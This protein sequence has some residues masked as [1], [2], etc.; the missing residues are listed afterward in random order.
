VTIAQVEDPLDDLASIDGPREGQLVAAK[1][2]SNQVH[3]RGS[4]RP[5]GA[6]I[7][8]GCADFGC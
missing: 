3:C 1:S 8:S 7:A 5:S 6:F 4:M 2:P